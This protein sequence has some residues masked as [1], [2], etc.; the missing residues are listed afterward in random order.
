MHLVHGWLE[1]LQGQTETIVDREKTARTA[2]MVTVRSGIY[3]YYLVQLENKKEI[4]SF[5]GE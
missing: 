2:L 5:I 1:H 4:E 3:C